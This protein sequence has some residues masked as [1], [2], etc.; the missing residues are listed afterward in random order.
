M[1]TATSLHPG[2][3]LG[4]TRDQSTTRNAYRRQESTIIERISDPEFPSVTGRA[5]T[6]NPNVTANI[7]ANTARAKTDHFGHNKIR[8]QTFTNPTEIET[9]TDR[10]HHRTQAGVKHNADT[11]HAWSQSSDRCQPRH[12]RERAV[13]TESVHRSKHRRIE[14]TPCHPPCLNRARD[15]QKRVRRNSNRATGSA[16]DPIDITISQETAP[17]SF[18]LSQTSLRDMDEITIATN[19]DHVRFGSHSREPKLGDRA[20]GHAAA[21]EALAVTGPGVA[22]ADDVNIDPAA[23]RLPLETV[24]TDEVPAA[25]VPVQVY[26]AEGAAT[27]M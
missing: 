22:V 13:V 10:N 20:I 26:V 3:H 19:N 1:H 18:Q 14:R 8:G 15:E 16:V 21:A 24:T 5:H 17:A 23:T 11:P 27:L 7:H 6:I 25:T 2:S 9:D 12:L 4:G